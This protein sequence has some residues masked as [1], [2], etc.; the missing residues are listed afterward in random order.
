MANGKIFFPIGIGEPKYKLVT[1][2]TQINCNEPIEISH[3]FKLHDYV[4]VRDVGEAMAT[5]SISK[6]DGEIDIGN[7]KLIS[8][9]K[10]VDLVLKEL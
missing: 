4:D 5:L 3:P 7:G 9:K 6:V 10:L 1:S 8:V 2:L